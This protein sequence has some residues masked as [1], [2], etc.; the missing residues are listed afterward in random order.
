MVVPRLEPVAADVEE[1]VIG[2]V[3]GRGEEDQ[4]QKGAVHARPVEKVG[5]DEEEEDK[6]RRGVGGDE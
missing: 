6:D 1:A 2:P 4:Q 3:A 5:A